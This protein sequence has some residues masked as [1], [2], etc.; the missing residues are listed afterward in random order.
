MGDVGKMVNEGGSYWWAV[1]RFRR[2]EHRGRSFEILPG[3][4][5]ESLI[6]TEFY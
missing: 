2:R 5:C 1:G 4:I 3:L 6:V